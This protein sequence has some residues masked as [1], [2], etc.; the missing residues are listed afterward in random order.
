MPN[1]MTAA[2]RQTAFAGL[3]PP[4]AWPPTP[5]GL[6]PGRLELGLDSLPGVGAS[7]RRKLGR[8]GL[9]TVWDVLEHRPRRYESA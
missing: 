2:R 6:R 9:R 8:L 5:R 1:T 3:D 4:E 7:L